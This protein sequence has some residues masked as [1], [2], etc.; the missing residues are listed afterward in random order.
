MIY[1]L[2]LTQLAKYFNL[3]GGPEP[4]KAPNSTFFLKTFFVFRLTVLIY[5][6]PNYLSLEL[7]LCNLLRICLCNNEGTED[8]SSIRHVSPLYRSADKPSALIGQTDS[9]DRYCT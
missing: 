9:V 2:A 6:P 5:I 4:K 7:T 8:L 1:E 3:V